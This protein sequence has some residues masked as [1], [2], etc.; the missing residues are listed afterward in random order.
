MQTYH[1]IRIIRPCTRINPITMAVSDCNL[2]CID[3]N[4]KYMQISISATRSKLCGGRI[5]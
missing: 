1:K 3:A 5:D 4:I 2:W